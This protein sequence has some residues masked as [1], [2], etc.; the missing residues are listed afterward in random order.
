MPRAIHLVPAVLALFGI[1]VAQEPPK[2]KPSYVPP[3]VRLAAAKTAFIR[4]AGGSE[5]PFNVISSGIEG[6]GRFT[7]V[8][9]AAK[10]DILVEVLSPDEEGGGGVS[11]SSRKRSGAGGRMEESASSSRNLS[12]GAIK[13]VVYDGRTHIA[14]WSA[15]EQPKGAMRQ[16]AREDNLVQSAGRLLAKLRERLEPPAPP[17]K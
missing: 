14:L 12:N 10:A 6:W 15:T 3:L 16:K 1:L 17:S 4:N 5:I 9:S 8:D 2:D 13:L 11:V 7:L